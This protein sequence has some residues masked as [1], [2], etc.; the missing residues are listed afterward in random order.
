MEAARKKRS[1]RRSQK[2]IAKQISKTLAPKPL[3]KQTIAFL[4]TLPFVILFVAILAS[5]LNYHNDISDP[6]NVVMS[7]ASTP[8]SNGFSSLSKV[9][10]LSES[11]VV[12]T[13][14]ERANLPIAL[15]ASN[16][17]KSI[18]IQ[19]QMIQKSEPVINK[20]AIVSMGGAGQSVK[21]HIVKE[22]ETVT[23][24]ASQYGISSQTIRWANNLINDTV[25]VGKELKILPV[26]GVYYKVKA[27]DTY[28]KIV[29]RYGSN[30][31]YIIAINSLEISGLVPDKMIVLPDGNLPETERPGYV[32]PRPRITNSYNTGTYFR[33][34]SGSGVRYYPWG[35]CTWFAAY[36]FPQL[37]GGKQVGNWGNANTWDNSA[38]GTYGY[39]VSSVP[40]A[41]AIFQTD[42]GWAGHVGIVES[43]NYNQNG[44]IASINVSDMNG[45]AGWGRV[46]YA[47]WDYS[48]YSRYKYIK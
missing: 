22:G 23:S 7:T 11:N 4:V 29:S 18:E 2:Q 31:G 37:N 21:T 33:P 8:I 38:A 13:L 44:S 17:A 9:D 48:K 30:Q 39:S 32:A 43:V 41:G 6:K 40:A 24:I 1:D 27:G 19:S 47:T 10:E 42:V 15:Y 14:A 3:S 26:D 45:I 20:P 25:E 36:R 34:A 28:E 16:S 46:G 35:W 12:A 5:Y